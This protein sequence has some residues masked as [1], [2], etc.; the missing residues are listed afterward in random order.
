MG[1]SSRAA[2][3][4]SM[5]GSRPSWRSTSRRP[6][7]TTAT[8]GLP[9]RAGRSLSGPFSTAA[10]RRA[11]PAGAG[12]RR[13]RTKVSLAFVQELPGARAPA[14]GTRPQNRSG[15]RVAGRA[16]RRQSGGRAARPEAFRLCEP[17]ASVRQ[18]LSVLGGLCLF[19][20]TRS[21]LDLALRSA[22][23]LARLGVQ[24]G[25]PEIRMNAHRFLG[26]I[27]VRMGRLPGRAAPHGLRAGAAARS[28]AVPAP[29]P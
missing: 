15:R 7:S 16:R 24:Q 20:L 2:V 28:L 5:P 11:C 10:R 19:H 21:E 12:W 14:A 23:Q 18:R 29:S 6:R 26:S 25:D 9:F 8:P 17:V 27:L 22:R 13:P 1:A 4:S 3:S